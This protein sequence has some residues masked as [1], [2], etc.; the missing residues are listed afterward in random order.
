MMGWKA[1]VP[2]ELRQKFQET[3]V[4]ILTTKHLNSLLED[5]AFYG[6]RHRYYDCPEKDT[7]KECE[8]CWGDSTDRDLREGAASFYS[9]LW[10]SVFDAMG[11]QPQLQEAEEEAEEDEEEDDDAEQPVKQAK[12]E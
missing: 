6:Q 1:Y 8:D 11:I 9:D 12:I 7:S 3:F 2:P 4:H 5:A 10:Q